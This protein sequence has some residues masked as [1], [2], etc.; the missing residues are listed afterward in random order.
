MDPG[1][2]EALRERWA[3]PLSAEPWSLEER[4]VPTPWTRP[5]FLPNSP[6][7]FQLHERRVPSVV[8]WRL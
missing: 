1:A 2:R 6:G 8:R 3:H 7:R 5:S 4:T